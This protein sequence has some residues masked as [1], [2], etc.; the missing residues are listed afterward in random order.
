MRRAQSSSYA[1]QQS[2]RNCDDQRSV[3]VSV[4]SLSDAKAT[5]MARFQSTEAVVPSD[6][7]LFVVGEASV[8]PFVVEF[9]ESTVGV[10]VSDAAS[11]LVARGV[12]TIAVPDAVGSPATGVVVGS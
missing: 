11:E 8:V 3:C 5:Y 7:D 2:H 12:P 10:M 6:S 9:P 4:L 1:V